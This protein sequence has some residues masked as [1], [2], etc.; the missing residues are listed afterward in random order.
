MGI[1]PIQKM[2]DILA[3][4]QSPMVLTSRRPIALATDIREIRARETLKKMLGDAEYRLFLKNGFVSVRGKSGR[5]YQI[6]PG[7]DFTRVFENGKC[8]E[9]LCIILNQQYPPTDSLLM[10]YCILLNDEE[11]FC[12]LANRHRARNTGDFLRAWRGEQKKVD[13]RPLQDI[14]FD[15]R[16]TMRDNQ[17]KGAICTQLNSWKIVA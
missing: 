3:S 1:T 2:R 10:R 17:Q 6:F 11:Q 13:H 5:I 16:N 15:M 9:E 12:H 7:H 4:R 14:L 8:V